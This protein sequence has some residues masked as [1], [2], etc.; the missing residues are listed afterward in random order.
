MTTDRLT[1][2]FCCNDDDGNLLDVVA[3]VEVDG[4]IQLEGPTEFDDEYLPATTPIAWTLRIVEVAGA[5]FRHHDRRRFAGN[6]LW[7]SVAMDRAEVVRLLNH[8]RTLDGWMCLSA[9]T[10]L[11]EAWER[12]E[13]TVADLDRAIGP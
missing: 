13:I 7:D 9:E 11:F 3:A 8:L 2:S 6:L 10:L 4:L 5:E 1:V 12:R